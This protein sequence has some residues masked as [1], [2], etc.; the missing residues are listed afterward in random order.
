LRK[1]LLNAASRLWIAYC[2][3]HFP[4]SSIHGHLSFLTEFWILTKRHADGLT[5]FSY[6]SFQVPNAQLYEKRA[7]P[8]ERAKK[9]ACALVG[10]SCMVWALRTKKRGE[11]FTPKL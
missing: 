10:M 11:F 8:Q 3:A 6:I 5:P 4:T 1:K 7:T 2:G 9:C